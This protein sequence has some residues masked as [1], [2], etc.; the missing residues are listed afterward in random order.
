MESGKVKIFEGEYSIDNLEEEITE[1]IQS[2]IELRGRNAKRIRKLLLEIVSKAF[3]SL[4]E[5]LKGS[6]S[7]THRSIE[8]PSAWTNIFRMDS[9]PHLGFGAITQNPQKVRILSE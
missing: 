1:Y 5:V 7:V 8:Y 6:A 3:S 2:E 9:C 4:K